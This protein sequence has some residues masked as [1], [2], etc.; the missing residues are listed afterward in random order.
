MVVVVRDRY[1]RVWCGKEIK[2][3]RFT[4]E[5]IILISTCEEHHV[6]KQFIGLVFFRSLK[7]FKQAYLREF[8]RVQHLKNRAPGGGPYWNPHRSLDA[9]NPPSLDAHTLHSRV[10]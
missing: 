10:A 3:S 9:S 5:Y 8:L 1:L 6:G 4:H 7:S 2:G